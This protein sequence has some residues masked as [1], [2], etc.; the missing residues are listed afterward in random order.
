VQVIPTLAAGASAS[1]KF[2]FIP[3]LTVAVSLKALADT[4]PGETNR[5]NNLFI[6]KARFQLGR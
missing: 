2:T 5:N 6:A 3:P 4:V 1:V